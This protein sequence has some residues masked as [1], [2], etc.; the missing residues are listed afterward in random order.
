MGKDKKELNI[1]D[2]NERHLD[3]TQITW[4]AE[5]DLIFFF[6]FSYENQSISTEKD[7][8]HYDRTT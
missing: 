7:E 5:K 2:A 6:F 4:F 1:D 3:P 8:E